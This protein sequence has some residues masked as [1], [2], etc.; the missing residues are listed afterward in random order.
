MWI[1]FGIDGW[2]LD[3]PNEID[4]DSFWREFR[5]RVRAANPEAYIVGEVWTDAER[6]LE[7]DM[8]DAVMN[9]QFTRACLAFFI[10]EAV[11]EDDLRRTSLFPVGPTTAEAFRRNIERLLGLYHPEVSGVMLNLLGSHDM[12]RFLTLARGDKS[13]LRLAT[14]FQMTYP[15]APSIYYGDEIGM[16]GGHDPANRGAFPW[17]KTEVWD[18]ELLHEFQRLIALRRQRPALR[19]GE[20]RFL[21]ADNNVVAYAR[22]LHD[23]TIVVALNA[24]RHSRRLDLPLGNLVADETVWAECWAHDT[25]RVEQGVLRNLAL[26]PRSGRVFA[27]PP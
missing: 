16:A 19:R 21:W 9:Y 8:W 13:A 10:G 14:L 20:F 7:G 11:N 4:D 12:A 17:H 2:R 5:Q 26:A 25:V 27:T 3:V 23:E 15:G 24:S 6:W 22:C 18:K 1:E